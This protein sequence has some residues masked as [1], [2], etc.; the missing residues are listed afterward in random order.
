M[1]RIRLKK[2]KYPM[3]FKEMLYQHFKSMCKVRGG[4]LD[5]RAIR[6]H[7]FKEWTDDTWNEEYDLF[8]YRCWWGGRLSELAARVKS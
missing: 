4:K 8:G 6:L 7:Y 3:W 2:E 5:G 1:K